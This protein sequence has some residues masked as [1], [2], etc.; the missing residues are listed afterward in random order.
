[1]RKLLLAML[2]ILAGNTAFGEWK[3][4]WLYLLGDPDKHGFTLHVDSKVV[5]TKQVLKV[6]YLLDYTNQ[7]RERGLPVHQSVVTVAEYDCGR[8]MERTLEFIPYSLNMAK[9]PKIASYPNPEPS[10]E[11]LGDGF[12]EKIWAFVCEDSD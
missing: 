8:M 6:A 7:Q 1:M 11:A 4:E 5:R 2:L 3:G 9:G 12:G 10:W